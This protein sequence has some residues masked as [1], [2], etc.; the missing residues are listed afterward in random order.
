MGTTWRKYEFWSWFCFY[1]QPFAA[2]TPLQPTVAPS[3]SILQPIPANSTPNFMD[4]PMQPMPAHSKNDGF[5]ALKSLDAEQP[6]QQ[7]YSSMQPA[8]TF[9]QMQ[10]PQNV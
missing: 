3:S 10:A 7:G 5:A 6:Q 9:T 2:S 8:Q 4:S 1:L